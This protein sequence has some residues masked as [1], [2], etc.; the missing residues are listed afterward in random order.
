MSLVNFNNIRVL[1][2][3][4]FS[5][6]RTTIGSMLNKLGVM[7][8]ENASTAKEA[9]ELCRVKTF[10]V[11]LCDHELGAGRTG[12]HVLE[13]LRHC[14]LLP[15]TSV[16]VLVSADVSRD[17]VMS[18]YDCQPDDY[19]A[20][21]ING[22][23]LE[24]RLTRL[25]NQRAP[26]KPALE[27][28]EAGDQRSA[29]IHLTDLAISGGR[30][31]LPAQKLLGELFIE[32]N[33]LD[34]AE[35]LYA[36]AL[37]VKSL[38]WAKLG[39]ARVKQLQGELASS[40]QDL[41]EIIDDNPL[42]L[43]AYD[44]LVDNYER[45]GE[46]KKVI[47]V[48][49]RSA[50]VSPNSILRQKKLA[51]LAE[52]GGD[53]R[54]ACRALK[55]ALKLGEKSV[56]GSMDDAL[57]LGRIVAKAPDSILEDD[58]FLLNETINAIHSARDHFDCGEKESIQMGFVEGRIHLKSGNQDKAHSVI[59]HYEDMCV[60]LEDNDIDIDIERIHALHD[61]GEHE[62][63][64]ILLRKLLQQYAYDQDALEKLDALLNE[65][66]S[67]ANK[68]MV[69]K[70]NRE[71]IDLY[72]QNLFDEALMC[73]DKARRSF[74]KHVGIQLNIVQTLLGKIKAGDG[75]VEVEKDMRDALDLVGKL[76]D[77]DYSQFSR[78]KRLCEMADETI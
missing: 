41:Q 38:D 29:I 24:K 71:G 17:V 10:D 32:S 22:Q 31:A 76:I 62:Q 6:F 11:V 2:A 20:K 3:D 60:L 55:K 15:L 72:N 5:S 78:Y 14:Q 53:V 39:M 67:E 27:S 40:Q 50:E 68:S 52:Q 45:Q 12:Q 13:E 73:F 49:Q 8:V 34:K 65:P 30:S 56:H 51:H 42:Y 63:A 44:S 75:G 4:D 33:Q 28:I 16:F 25:L 36:K 19:L 1:V 59:S 58:P 70:I 57:H 21:P 61:I 46:P 48:V 35:K 26:L 64:D 47:E 23:M 43:P 77:P 7:Q 37:E 54:T 18:A 74:P 9:I 69:A 66:V